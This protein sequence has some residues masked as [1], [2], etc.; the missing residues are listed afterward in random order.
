MDRQAVG[1][2]RLVGSRF[3]PVSWPLRKPAEAGRGV[4]ANARPRALTA[5]LAPS[6]DAAEFWFDNPPF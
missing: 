4:A 3:R 6:I 2:S 1:R 5:A